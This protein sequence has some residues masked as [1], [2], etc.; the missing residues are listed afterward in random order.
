MQTKQGKNKQIEI[1]KEDTNKFLKDIQQNT[2][3]QVKEISKTV[4]DILT[5]GII[6]A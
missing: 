6:L 3:K 4:Q 5:Q 2:I 1:F